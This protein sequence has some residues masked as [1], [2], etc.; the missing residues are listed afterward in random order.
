MTLLSHCGRAKVTHWAKRVNPAPETVAESRHRSA[1]S[2]PSFRRRE[3]FPDAE[4]PHGR[5]AAR[6]NAYRV[7]P[8]RWSAAVASSTSE[9]GRPADARSADPP[10]SSV[11][12]TESP[13]AA[14]PSRAQSPPSA[15]FPSTGPMAAG[16]IRQSLQPSPA[17]H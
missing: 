13:A 11:R 17:D 4:R 15:S 9:S 12:H 6:Q 2:P 1:S 7:S 10:S 5:Q 16:A 8:R 3:P 14:P